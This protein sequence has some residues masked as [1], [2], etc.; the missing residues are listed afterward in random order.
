MTAP[1]LNPQTGARRYTGAEFIIRLAEIHRLG[2]LAVPKPSSGIDLP[3]WAAR[4]AEE[5]KANDY[6]LTHPLD[7]PKPTRKPRRKP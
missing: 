5:A 6:R 2:T 4:Y 3:A 7:L 1:A